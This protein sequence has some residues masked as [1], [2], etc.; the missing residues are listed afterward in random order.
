M[1]HGGRSS[2]PQN[3]E[4]TFF[5]QN[6]G[7]AVFSTYLTSHRDLR[8]NILGPEKSVS[9]DNSWD[10]PIKRGIDPS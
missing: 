6:P 2:C 10:L 5:S 8:I 4:I 1:S 9:R 3:R 7:V